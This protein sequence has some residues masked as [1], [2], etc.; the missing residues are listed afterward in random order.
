MKTCRNCGVSKS[1]DL[2]PKQKQ[3]KDGHHS[4]CKQCRAAYDKA[5]YNPEK[6]NNEYVQNLEL[7]RQARRE[8]YSENKDAYYAR[9]AK[10]RASLLNR[11]PKWLSASDLQ[12]MSAIYQRCAFLNKQSSEKYE[13]DHIVPLQGETVS[14]L[15][16]PW[17]LQIIPMFENRS[18]GN[19]LK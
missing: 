7:E 12:T 1:L 4:Y 2:F 18:K 17:N 19:K 3:N 10:R 14:G 16:V 11:T 5:R 6:R 13:V 8:Y 9:K 15:H